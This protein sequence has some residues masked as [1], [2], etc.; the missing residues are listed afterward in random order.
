M[1]DHLDDPSL[2][3]ASTATALGLS[4]RSLDRAFAEAG[5]SAS[6]TLW[7]LRLER[8][9]R[10]LVVDPRAGISQIAFR[11][12]FSDAAHFSR[13]FRAAFGES[14]SAYRAARVG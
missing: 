9:R 7:A 2:T 13:A 3:V 6:R 11:W 1:L 4:R 8:C 12:G 14:P 5:Q 10:D